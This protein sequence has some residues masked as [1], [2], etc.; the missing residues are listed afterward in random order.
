MWGGWQTWPHGRVRWPP[1]CRARDRVST[2]VSGQAVAASEG[3]SALMSAVRSAVR[4]CGRL[5]AA[6]SGVRVRRSCPLSAAVRPLSGG[7]DAPRANNRI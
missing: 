4:A 6:L 1:L 7:A 2:A 3:L 5:S